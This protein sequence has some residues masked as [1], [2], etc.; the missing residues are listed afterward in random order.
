MVDINK[1]A[2]MSYFREFSWKRI[3]QHG[4]EIASASVIYIYMLSLFPQIFMDFSD[5][6]FW[7]YLTAAIPMVWTAWS[8]MCT[9]VRLPKLMFMGP[10]SMEERRSYLQKMWNIRFWFPNVLLI[11]AIG[12]RVIFL[13]DVWLFG[14]LIIAQNILMSCG[15]VYAGMSVD[16]KLVELKGIGIF[17]LQ[18]FL[19]LFAEMILL[20]YYASETDRLMKGMLMFWGALLVIQLLNVKK[21]LLYKQRM[22]DIIVDYEKAYA[23]QDAKGVKTT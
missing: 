3:K 21:L 9:S 4:R 20:Y 2:W 10:M 12:I 22:L 5:P 23:V 15:A 6:E 8:M 7:V 1:L 11:V 16:G 14:V 13:P 18:M 19:G 17:L